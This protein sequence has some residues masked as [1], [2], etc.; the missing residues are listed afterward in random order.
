MIWPNFMKVPP[1][2]WKLLRSG[3]ASCAAGSTP[4]RM[5]STWRAAVGVKWI[6][7]TLAMVRLRRSSS[8]CVGSGR[9]RG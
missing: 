9:R 7:T 6:A 8:R 4:W 1:R 3:R 2:S 5:C